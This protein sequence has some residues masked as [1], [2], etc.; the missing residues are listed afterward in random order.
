MN[1][2]NLINVIADQLP[3]LNKSESKVAKVILADPDA[4]T[5]SSIAALAKAAS[6]SEPSVNRFCK[7]FD[8][9]GFP[10]FK[11]R[12]AKA[13]VSGVRFV[14]AMSIRMMMSVATRQRFS[15]AQL[16]IW[17]WCVIASATA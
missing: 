4:A 15:I 7:R 14:I 16:I 2:Q 8:A 1:G 12:L 10:D 3:N 5:Q 6:V 17:R 9:A 13:L 11:L